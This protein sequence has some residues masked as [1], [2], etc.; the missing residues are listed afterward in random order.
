MADEY[1][2]RNEK[3]K[4]DVV[5]SDRRTRSAGQVTATDADLAARFD[6]NK[7][8]YRIGEKRKIK[9]ALVDVDK[10]RAASPSP[11]PTS[12]RSTS[13]TS[14]ST[15]R[16][17]RR[18]RATS[19]SRPR[20]RTRTRCRAQAEEVLKKA[21]AGADFA[22]LAKQYSEDDSN[23]D[24]GGDLDYFGKGRMVPEFERR[25]VRA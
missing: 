3:V 6:K 7:E 5:P 21:R 14:R 13:R 15:R 25:G 1:R 11:T 17:R 8:S 10:V 19:C 12:R 24:R 22:E 18:A 9:Y 23:K 16:R 20:A 2:R 4:L